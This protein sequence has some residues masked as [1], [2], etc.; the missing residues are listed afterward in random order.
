MSRSSDQAPSDVEASREAASLREQATLAAER[1]RKSAERVVEVEQI[2]AEV[3]A[4]A[5]ALEDQLSAES[6][7][8]AELTQRLERAERVLLAMK[9]SVSWRMTAPLRAL[10]RRR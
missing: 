8:A 5:V 4:R 3:T 1:S 2:V 6:A 9:T 7:R 10:K